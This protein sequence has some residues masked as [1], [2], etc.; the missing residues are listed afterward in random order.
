MGGVLRRKLQISGQTI[1]TKSSILGGYDITPDDTFLAMLCS[2]FKRACHCNINE[3]LGDLKTL[4]AGHECPNP[5]FLKKYIGSEREKYHHTAIKILPGEHSYPDI[6]ITSL[7]PNRT[8]CGYSCIK[9]KWANGYYQ[10]RPSID[11]DRDNI[12]STHGFLSSPDK[13]AY[14]I[15][16]DFFDV[17]W[18]TITSERT[19]P[20]NL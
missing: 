17:L 8:R 19:T 6:I 11:M 5:R 14:L 7:R 9:L 16:A 3:V 10:H 4:L 18:D 15:P 20:N 12:A 2:L 13:F 1:M